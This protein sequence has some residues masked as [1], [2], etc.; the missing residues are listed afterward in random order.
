MYG[1]DKYLAE[2]SIE[3]S[4]RELIKLRACK[5]TATLIASIY[6]PKTLGLPAKANSAFTD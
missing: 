2:S 6:T 5:S 4:L 1:L 3:P